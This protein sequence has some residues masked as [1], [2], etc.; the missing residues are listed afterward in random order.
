MKDIINQAHRSQS[1]F[2]RSVFLTEK[3]KRISRK[4]LMSFIA[5]IA[6]VK[7]SRLPGDEAK[8]YY[9]KV[10]GSYLT[11]EG[12]EDNL[13]F[14]L[15][16]GITEQIQNGG[17][18]PEHTANI[19]FNPQEQKW[20]GWSHRAI[21]GF[22]IGSTCKKGDCHYV[23]SSIAEQ[24]EAAI[25]FW[26]DKYHSKVWCD[27]IVEVG[28]N[29]FFDIKWEYNN[30]VPNR[31]LRGTIGGVLHFITPL[32]RGEWEAKTIDDAKQ[33]AIDFANGVA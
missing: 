15:K 26:Q 23:G 6:D 12:M 11:R 19:G 27:G 1:L 3:M 2:G 33:M 5:K 17:N 14:L 21:C 16:F 22:G 31:K 28:G 13:K 18:N 8:C 25:S 10:G 20:Y 30:K 7:P 32:G 9:S 29:K 4:M 24:E